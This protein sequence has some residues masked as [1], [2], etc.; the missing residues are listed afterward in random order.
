[1]KFKVKPN[2][3]A[4][5]SIDPNTFLSFNDS[6]F[7]EPTF[8]Y[9]EEDSTFTVAF[10]FNQDIYQRP[11]KLMFTAS[12]TIDARFWATN[13]TEWEFII[14]NDDSLVIGYYS[15]TEYILSRII[16]ILSI[17]L[18]VSALLICLIGVFSPNRLAGLE[19][20]FVLQYGYICLLW[21][22]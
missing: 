20:L 17:I 5:K 3:H 18:T 6:S 8:I 15:D 2:L 13:N 7:L 9:H 21:L 19:I 22:S 16:F 1:M 11:F 10:T 14:D 4:F 12:S